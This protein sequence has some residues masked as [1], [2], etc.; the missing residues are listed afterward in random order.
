MPTTVD[1]IE[2]ERSVPWM[3]TVKFPSW[4]VF[5]S[6]IGKSPSG[7]CE[8][9]YRGQRCDNWLLQS[10]LSRILMSDAKYRSMSDADRK[11][12]VDQHYDGFRY[13]IRGRRGPLAGELIGD[14]LWAL[15]QHHGLATPLLDWSMS[16]YVAAYFAFW[17]DGY[18]PTDFRVVFAANKDAIQSHC[19]A[20]RSKAGGG[21]IP[22][23]A[24]FSPLSEDN[25]RL[26]N[27]GGL[28]SRLPIDT[29]LESWLA[30]Y[31]SPDWN[32]PV[33]YK[34][35]IPNPESAT[36]VRS[37]AQMNINGLTLFPDLS[38]SALFC[39]TALRR[40]GYAHH[41]G[42]PPPMKMR[43]QRM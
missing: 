41:L 13:A 8:F 25:S 22:D 30:E 18:P 26:T 19:R 2:V 24:F 31:H 20:I 42:S 6:Y 37:L 40:E 10:S 5:Q 17:E 9:V 43:I 11:L 16:P 3:E 12:C 7:G 28:F 23:V 36:V 35:L 27:Q 39:N 34:L 15:G 1:S 21:N 33:L 4:A 29:D 14:Y 38:G 32:E